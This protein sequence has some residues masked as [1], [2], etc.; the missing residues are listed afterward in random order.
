MT[1]S[2]TV[3]PEQSNDARY[4]MRRGEIETY[5]DRTAVDAWAR[6]TSTAPVGRVRATVRAGRDM[7][8]TTLLSWLPEDLSGRRVLDA[9]CGTGALAV[10]A[11]LRGAHVVAIDLSP[12][13][14][15]LAAERMPT[16][17]RGSVEWHCGDMLDAK[18]GHFDHIVCM[19]SVIHYQTDDAAKAL[20][21]LAE[22]TSRSIA[23]TIAPG[24]AVLNTM[25]KI[26]QL[27]PRGDRSPSIVP[28]SPFDLGRKL[29]SFNSISGWKVER[30]Q[31]VSSGFYKSHAMELVAP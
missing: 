2:N 6:L 27:F 18:L 22:R 30:S 8:R 16:N 17:L 12:T 14:V 7:M 1:R 13:L 20:A 24:N 23:F 15:N 11:A 5:F 25:L 26:G 9:G 29:T 19:D 4:Q 31:R 28:T 21:K 10:E 3:A